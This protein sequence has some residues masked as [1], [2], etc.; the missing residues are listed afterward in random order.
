MNYSNET[1]YAYLRVSTEKQSDE[2]NSLQFQ[3]RKAEKLADQ[4]GFRDVKIFNEGAISGTTEPM[5]REAFPKLHR[6]IQKGNCKHLFV[7]EYSRLSRKSFWSEWLRREFVENDVKLW[8]GDK[9]EPKDLSDPMDQLI[10]GI[11]NKVY[12]FERNNMAKRIKSGLE[13]SYEKG[14]WQGVQVPYG[15]KRDD[16]GLVIIDKDQAE[17]YKQMVNMIHK[18]K[19]IRDI[20]NWLNDNNIPTNS[21]KSIDKGYVEYDRDDGTQKVNTEEM[22]WR[23]NVVR[24]ILESELR[25]GVRKVGG[26]VYD[27]PAIISESRWEKLQQRMEDNKRFHH[28]GNRTKHFYLLKG[29]L[30]CKRHEE[31]DAKL[32]GK[33]KSDQRSYYCARK[34]KAVRHKN[35]GPCQLPSPNI[36]KM[37]KFVWETFLE[38]FTNSYLVYKKFK[39]KV[40]E[41]NESVSDKDKLESQISNLRNELKVLEDKKQRLLDLYLDN[42]LE[43]DQFKSKKKSL[44]SD[45]QEKSGK[46]KRLTSYLSLVD[47]EEE[48]INWIDEFVEEVK[49]W[50]SDDISQERKRDL[51][52]Q[53]IDKIMVDYDDEEEHYIVDF[54]FRY[55]IIEDEADIDPFS[56]DF[57]PEKGDSHKRVEIDD[58]TYQQSATS[59]TV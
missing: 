2:G 49:R 39:Q 21:A 16:D 50:Q 31:Y 6:Q 45:I 25:K 23:D 33:I 11:L 28:K 15:Y 58:T 51:L 59:E 22:V 56:G 10:S 9:G 37:N 3:K 12:E 40:L 17:I 41:E 35:E 18:G 5:E 24:G 54:Y 26:K 53:H 29:L 48:T 8:V 52:R 14:K 36:D 19:S 55:P 20:V 57:E 30:F 47:E 1:L 13:E 34:R 4:H 42:A 46:I 43:K 32:L 38:I 44:T 27:F 7:Y